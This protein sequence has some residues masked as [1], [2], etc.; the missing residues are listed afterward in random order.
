MIKV[1]VIVPVYNAGECLRPCLDSLINPTL[2]ELEI[3]CV[4]DCPTDGSDKIVDEYAT[5]DERVV[6][7][8]NLAMW[9][10]VMPRASILVSPTMMTSMN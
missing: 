10:Y 2:R 6:V 7:V 8:K 9:V 3:I 1:S 4:L 5:K